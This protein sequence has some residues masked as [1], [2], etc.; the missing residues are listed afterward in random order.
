MFPFPNP[1]LNP[2]GSL[3]DALISRGLGSF[4]DVVLW[5]WKLPYGRNSGRSDFRLVIEEGR[6]T[7]STK[8]ALLAQLADELGIDLQ[9]RVGIFLMNEDN[10]PEIAETLRQYDLHEIP[11]AH[12]F[13]KYGQRQFDFTMCKDGKP[14]L[15][16]HDFVYE[17]TIRPSQIGEYKVSLHQEWIRRWM[18]TREF[19]KGVTLEEFW[20]ARERCI[21]LLEQST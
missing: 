15:A 20:Q 17:E 4:H 8:H 2:N 5:V 10:T 14:P 3:S 12:C 1:L 7:C 18:A 21:K 11:E 13:L 16:F 9:L 19:A 6:G